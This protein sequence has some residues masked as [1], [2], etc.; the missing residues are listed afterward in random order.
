[1]G[2]SGAIY[3]EGLTELIQTLMKQLSVL[4]V[5]FDLGVF[6]RLPRIVP[7][8][9]LWNGKDELYQPSKY[10]T[11]SHTGFLEDSAVLTEVTCE[12]TDVVG[13]LDPDGR[14]LI[15]FRRFPGDSPL[16]GGAV[17][18][19]SKKVRRSSPIHAPFIFLLEAATEPRTTVAPSS[20]SSISIGL[21]TEPEGGSF[22]V[23]SFS[24]VVAGVGAAEVDDVGS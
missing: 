21:S 10:P 24:P 6:V 7:G 11:E 15:G 5:A 3:I 16:G 22:S 8:R 18:D 19:N 23:C 9:R 13:S 4:P 2:D 1:V 17:V 14:L 20:E 12:L